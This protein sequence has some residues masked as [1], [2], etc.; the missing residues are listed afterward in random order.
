MSG[1]VA[2]AP[3][4]GATEITSGDW[5][6]PIELA[7]ARTILRVD[8]TI[9]DDRMV[10]CLMV[11]MSTVEDDLDCWQQ[12]QVALGRATLADVPS[13]AFNGTSRLVLLY[14]HAVYCSAQAE[15]IERYR[16]FDATAAS[17]HR[18]ADDCTTVDDY[19]RYVRFAVRDILGRPR[20]DVE[21]L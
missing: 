11:A 3:A 4:T 12:Q 19:R 16:N 5:Y 2:T 15:L 21:L 17:N 9:T 10:E 8:G 20:S 6:P 18:V 14:R 7:D 13:K 1:L